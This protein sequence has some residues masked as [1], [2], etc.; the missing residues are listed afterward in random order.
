MSNRF[1]V[2]VHGRNLL[3]PMVDSAPRRLGFFAT[4]VVR[5]EDESLALKAAI[6]ELKKEPQILAIINTPADP[7]V[8]EGENIVRLRFWEHRWRRLRGFSFY[9]VES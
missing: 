4:R 9:A 1:K 2:L 7:P 5:A 8:F 6:Q 3:V